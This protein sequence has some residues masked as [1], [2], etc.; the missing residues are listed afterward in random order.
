ML[1]DIDLLE[2]K[3][4]TMDAIQKAAELNILAS[5]SIVPYVVI[6]VSLVVLALFVRFSPLPQIEDPEEEEGSLATQ[7][8]IKHIQFSPPLDRNCD[9]VPVRGS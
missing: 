8:E 6:M 9:P 1:K 4:Q 7:R 3:L 2:A 5:K